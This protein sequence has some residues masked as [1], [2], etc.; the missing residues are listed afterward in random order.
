MPGEVL[1][2][3]QQSLLP[4]PLHD[5]EQRFHARKFLE[6][7]RHELLQSIVRNIV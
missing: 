2:D 3:V 5:P 1:F 7:L 4:S 6:L